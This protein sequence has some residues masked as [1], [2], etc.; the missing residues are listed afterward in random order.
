MK[1]ALA[2]ALLLAAG[3]A[4]ADIKVLVAVDPSDRA[5]YLHY[6]AELNRSAA[7]DPL[8]RRAFYPGEVGKIGLGHIAGDAVICHPATE[9]G[10]HLIVCHS[11]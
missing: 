4:A 8:A 3:T 2:L 11:A 1:S 7:L 10:H 6:S 5:Q 9:V